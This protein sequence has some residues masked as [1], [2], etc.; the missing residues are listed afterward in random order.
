MKLGENILLRVL[1]VARISVGFDQTYKDRNVE[2]EQ[3]WFG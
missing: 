1:Y 2:I 3:V